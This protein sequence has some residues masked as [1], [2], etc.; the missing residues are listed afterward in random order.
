M[1]HKRA[2]FAQKVHGLRAKQFNKKRY[3]EKATMK[4]TSTRRH[5]PPTTP[6]PQFHYHHD[7]HHLYARLVTG[8]QARAHYHKNTKSKHRGTQTQ[9]NTPTYAHTYTHTRTHARTQTHAHTHAHTRTTA[10]TLRQIH[11][12]P[13]LLCTRKR[14]A[15]TRPRMP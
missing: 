2:E 8:T 10:F 9:R 6:P 11:Q 3:A 5:T 15:N 1:V 4:K 13:G 12:L 14:V 7:D